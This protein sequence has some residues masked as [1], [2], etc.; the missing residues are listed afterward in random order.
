MNSKV[1]CTE[2]KNDEVTLDAL[3]YWNQETQNWVVF[4]V[5]EPRAWCVQCQTDTEWDM[6]DI[7]TGGSVYQDWLVSDIWDKE[8]SE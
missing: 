2:C 4:D 6:V 3:V 1:I 7:E 5:A 8:L